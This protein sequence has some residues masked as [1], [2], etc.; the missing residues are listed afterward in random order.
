MSISAENKSVLCFPCCRIELVHTYVWIVNRPTT[1][2]R[3]CIYRTNEYRFHEWWI[4]FL[5]LARSLSH[6][7]TQN[8]LLLYLALCPSAADVS[9]I[10]A[11][12]LLQTLKI[13]WQK[14]KKHRSYYVLRY[15]APRAVVVN[16]F[17]LSVRP[18]VST[19][20]TYITTY[21]V[22]CI[23]VIN[24]KVVVPSQIFP[25]IF[26]FFGLGSRCAVLF[27]KVFKKVEKK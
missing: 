13:L 3:T 1:Y 8:A 15:T 4:L 18:F 19:Y 16:V 24:A 22:S 11:M 23:H 10:F 5:S 2:L 14:W 21:I 12:R 27:F 25:G 6:T 17:C 9:L 7:H 20:R 26:I